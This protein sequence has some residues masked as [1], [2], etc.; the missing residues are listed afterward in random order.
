MLEVPFGPDIFILPRRIQQPWRHHFG[1]LLTFIGNLCFAPIFDC[2]VDQCC[3]ATGPAAVLAPEHK[4]RK[5]LNATTIKVSN[6]AIPSTTN[7]QGGTPRTSRVIA[8]A[9]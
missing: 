2:Q 1:R 9:P 3:P 8:V 7:T 6:V 5:S 4:L